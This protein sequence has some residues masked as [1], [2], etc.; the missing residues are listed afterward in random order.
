MTRLVHDLPSPRHV[1]VLDNLEERQ[2]FG[3]PSGVSLNSC[4]FKIAVKTI[5]KLHAVGISHKLMLMQNFQQQEALAA[6][7]K[8]CEDVEVDGE[9][10]FII[11]LQST[12]KVCGETLELFLS[13]C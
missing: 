7:K 13:S 5:A 10:L 9:L 3:I 11:F 2:F 4:H 1:L 12:G 8:T 6:A